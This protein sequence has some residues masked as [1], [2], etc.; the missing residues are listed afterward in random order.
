MGLEV[1]LVGELVTLEAWCADDVFEHIAHIAVH[2]LDVNAPGFHVV[3][4]FLRLCGISRHHQVV[5]RS[6]FLCHGQVFALTYP[7]GHHD[8]LKAPLIAQNGGEQILT[9]LCVSAVNL[10]VGRHKC[11][12]LTPA[13]HHL[14]AFEIEFAQGALAHALIDPCTVALLRVDGIM[15]GTHTHALTLY[16]LHHGRADE[17]RHHRIFTVILEVAATKRIAVEIHSGAENHVNAILQ[18]L[19]ANGP[20]HLFDECRVPCGSQTGAHGKTGGK[21]CLVG[22]VTV[23][24]D[25]HAC[26]TVGHHRCG[27][28]QPGYGYCRAGSTGHNL[29]LVA[30]HSAGAH[31][32]GIAA[33]YEKLCFLLNGH[34]C[35]HFI[36][37]VCCELWNLLCHHCCG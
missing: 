5:A 23:G 18:C 27:D 1:G 10:V 31:E 24:I 37:V 7:V 14:K 30:Q 16:A 2:I 21:E 3:D 15:F 28:A 4:D 9:A 29:L 20:A 32:A 26:R 6:H 35:Q 11:P 34:G 33:A 8:A 12:R 19:V 13:R 36:D 25:M 17:A 22:A